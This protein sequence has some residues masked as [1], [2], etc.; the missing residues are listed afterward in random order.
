MIYHEFGLYYFFTIIMSDFA[1]IIKQS[2]GDEI[3]ATTSLK[4]VIPESSVCAKNK[5]DD[6]LAILKGRYKFFK[7]DS[8]RP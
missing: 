7:T 4:T 1:Y 6:F 3:Y 5:N 8:M 2:P